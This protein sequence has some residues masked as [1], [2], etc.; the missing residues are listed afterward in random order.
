MHRSKLYAIMIDCS[1]DTFDASVDFWSGALG[2]A[3]ARPDDPSDPYVPLKGDGSPLHIMLQRVHDTSRF[4]LDIETDDV[5]A[6]VRRL[7]ALGAT[8]RAYIE[9]W[10]VMRAPSGHLFCVI[11]P[12]SERSLDNAT[13]WED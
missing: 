8:R 2:M 13:S 6:E 5:E 11:P 12:Q 10:W 9:R 4:H 3:P 1:E 7:E